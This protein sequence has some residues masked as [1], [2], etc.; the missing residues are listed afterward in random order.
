VTP[1]DVAQ[2]LPR[3]A[4]A[5]D[6]P[7]GNSSA[8][9]TLLCAQ[10]ARADGVE[11]LL[12]GDGGDELFGGNERYARQKVFDF[13]FRLPGRLRRRVLEPF[14]ARN[15]TLAWLWP[16]RK[17]RSYVQQACVPM[18]ERLQTWN[19]MYRTGA[20]AVFD[21][22]FLGSVDA[23]EPLDLM[24]ATYAE[25]PT[26]SLVDRMLYLDWKITLADND[27]RKVGRMCELAGVKVGYPMLD[28]AVVDASLKV[29]ADQ[30][31]RGLNLR[32]FYKRTFRDFLPAEVIAKT[33]HGFGLPFG[34]WVKA[35]APLRE[36]I[37][38]SLQQ[39]KRREIVQPAFIDGLVREFETDPDASYFG[40]MIW[41][42]S[43]LE[44]WLA[45]RRL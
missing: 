43:L 12:A 13:Y 16:A 1:A 2:C 39:L 24:A 35:S 36:E 28:E 40:P 7:F 18:P 3:I 37:Y 44:H 33:K 25:A 20:A 6:E 8:V 21:P 32:A 45:L 5:Y 14:A 34:Q 17:L 22:A 41:V 19:Y 4:A 29:P 9:P 23:R 27:L 10:R 42:F 15:G 30:K 38:P 26:E 31:V 11:R